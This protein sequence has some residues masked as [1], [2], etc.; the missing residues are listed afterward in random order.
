MGAMS[1]S[2][3]QS[4]STRC[5][6]FAFCFAPPAALTGRLILDD[7]TEQHARRFREQLLRP[8]RAIFRETAFPLGALGGRENPAANRKADKLHAD[9]FV[10]RFAKRGLCG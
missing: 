5:S 8:A 4:S 6:H 9:F 3:A 1:G 2:F 10:G 7:A